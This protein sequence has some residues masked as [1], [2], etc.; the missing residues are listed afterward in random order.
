MALLLKAQARVGLNK[1]NGMADK[2][3]SYTIRTPAEL[4]LS[5][6]PF[7]NGGGLFI[8]TQDTYFL[9]DQ[10]LIHLQLTDKNKTVD[11]EGKVVWLTPANALHHVIPG[12]GVQ[13]VGPDAATIRSKIEANL[14]DKIE[15]GGYTYGITD[16]E[17]ISNKP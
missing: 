7:I 17:R 6:M 13:F 10:I 11:I 16:N 3:I 8:P 4:N 14:A 5:Y 9:G 15:V 1:E 12:I 2:S